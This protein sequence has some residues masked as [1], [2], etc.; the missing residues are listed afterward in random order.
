MLLPKISQTRHFLHSAHHPHIRLF[1]HKLRVPP[2][3]LREMQTFGAHG[4]EKLLSGSCSSGSQRQGKHLWTFSCHSMLSQ[5]GPVANR[6][7]WALQ[8]CFSQNFISTLWTTK[9]LRGQFPRVVSAPLQ[10]KSRNSA[11]YRPRLLS[12]PVASHRLHAIGSKMEICTTRN[13]QK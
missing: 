6:K 10:H 8:L 4:L 9:M 1:H 13:M 2:E 12:T 7:G 3:S 11:F 5:G